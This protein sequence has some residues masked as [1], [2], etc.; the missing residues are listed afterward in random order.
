MNDQEE[1]LVLTAIANQLNVMWD[2]SI[3]EQNIIQQSQQLTEQ[4]LKASNEMYNL[5]KL[6]KQ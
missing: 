6:L 5:I 4:A 1:R 2:A 3:T